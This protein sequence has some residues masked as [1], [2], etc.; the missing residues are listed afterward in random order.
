[1]IYVIGDLLKWHEYDSY[2]NNWNVDGEQ[3]NGTISKFYESLLSKNTIPKESVE[4]VKLAFDQL[5][6]Y[7]CG[8]SSIF[9]STC[10][11]NT[12]SVSHNFFWVFYFLF[13]FTFTFNFFLKYL[14]YY[15]SQAL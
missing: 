1:M 15:N 13:V 12:Y 4:Q 11:V 5:Y 6:G 7:K 8:N 9:S 14:I 3:W 10:E 2:W